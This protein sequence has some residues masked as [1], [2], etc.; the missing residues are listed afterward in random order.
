[1]GPS[2]VY[3]KKSSYEALDPKV[4]S[5]IYIC[6][7]TQEIFKGETPLREAIKTVNELPAEMI[8][9]TLYNVNGNLYFFDGTKTVD[10]TQTIIDQ[11]SVEFDPRE[12][13][14]K[15]ELRE[16]LEAE[17]EKVPELSFDGL[18]EKLK[19]N[20]YNGTKKTLF[21]QLAE[22]LNHT[23]VIVINEDEG[24]IKIVVGDEEYASIDEAFA[25]VTEGST[26]DLVASG[27][28][29]ENADLSD[30]ANV[31]IAGDGAVLDA[32]N[33]SILL[34]EGA[35]VEGASIVNNAQ[36][37]P[38]EA[39]DLI[40]VNGKKGV[41]I[42]DSDLATE[43]MCA[44]VLENEAEVV[45]DNVSLFSSADPDSAAGAYDSKSMVW[46]NGGSEL[47]F[48]GGEII[49][50]SSSADDCGLY[51]IS[52]SGNGTVVVGDEA[53]NEGPVIKTNSAPFASNHMNGG[54]SN[55]TIY[56]GEYRSLMTHTGFMG[57]FYMGASSTIEVF[58]GKFEGGN[59]D[60]ACPY[61]KCQYNITIHGGEW[62]GKSLVNFG[63]KGDGPVPYE[64]PG[65]TVVVDGGSFAYKVP[66]EFIAEGYGCTKDNN[67]RW[68]VVPVN[69][70]IEGGAEA[71]EDTGE[72][73]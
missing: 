53:T 49:A 5:S 39:A 34:G 69:T 22:V 23:E 43:T 15:S 45:L 9:N 72:D 6:E 20:G 64:N 54:M 18:Y 28:M 61:K 8:A 24:T 62:D 48:V 13:V 11:I 63:W 70:I 37:A 42:V 26:V 60:I 12:H 35:R 47:T 19:L 66:D 10:V 50:N 73:F 56:G 4:A 30:V 16:A 67:G 40:N 46:V 57:V 21:A 38:A 1:M 2:I 14:K 27:A 36:V 52:I 7:D 71:I 29:A 68:V 31:T 65:L 58:D 59:Y 55:I 41:V 25:A 33:N 17:E 3:L 32:A 51:G 44:L